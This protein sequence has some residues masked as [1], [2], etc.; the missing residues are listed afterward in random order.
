M[1]T[2]KTQI[3]TAI[4]FMVLAVASV[5][6]CKSKKGTPI[7]KETGAKEITVP[8]S[9]KEFQSDKEYF[10][11]KASGNSIDMMTA[12][13]IAMQNAKAEMAGLIQ[14]TVKRVTEQYTN[15]RQIGNT[16]EFSNKFEEI[17]RE[18]TNQELVD[19]R[20]LGEKILKETNN[21]FTY[22]VAI[23]ANKQS[24]L[25]GIDKGIGANQ[26]LQQDYDKKKFEEIFNSEMEK[27]AKERGN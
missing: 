12:K 14:S 26:K 8:F 9:T 1:K 21:S 3:T 24:I 11:A 27:L 23:E 15:Q 25:N 4:A 16:Q 7:E 17:A 19:V 5:S 6:S 18:V 2:T 10:R 13:K 20:V 22:W